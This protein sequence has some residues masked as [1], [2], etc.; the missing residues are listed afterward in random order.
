MR[1]PL[2]PAV[3]L[4]LALVACIPD[5]TGGDSGILSD[6]GTADGGTTDG[7]TTD[8]GATDG[9]TT[10]G[11]ATDGGATDGG[12]SEPAWIQGQVSGEVRVQLYTLR[13]S[14]GER[15]AV[16]WEDTEFGETFPFGAI[17]VA[18]TQDDGA[19]RLAYRGQDTIAAP[20]VAG[21]PYSV[22]VSLPEDGGVQLYATLD[23]HGDGILS[24]TEPIGTFPGQVMVTDGSAEGDKDIVILVNYDE[25]LA[26]WQG[27]GGP[28]GGTGTCD[29]PVTLSGTASI[30]TS[31]A[32]GDVAV[33]LYDATGAGPYTWDRDEPVSTGGGAEAPFSLGVCGPLGEM[34][35]LGAW[36]SN[37]NGLIDLADMWGAVISKPEVSAN[38]LDIQSTDLAGLEVQIPL[39]DGRSDLGVVPFVSLSGRV[40]YMNGQVFDKLPTDSTVH[41]VAM[42]YRPDG[43]LQVTELALLSYDTDTWEP[44]DYAGQTELPFHLWV[45]GN[46]LVYLWGFVDEGPKPDGTVNAP[47]ELVGSGGGDLTGRLPTGTSSTSDLR[48]DLG[49]G[50]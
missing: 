4:A 25:A 22:N 13:E 23:Y 7:G 17:M 30:T 19:G 49:Y 46:T 29:D 24:T 20:T 39:G 33:L 12:T 2:I 8:G 1:R 16:A 6:G 47:F 32:G 38:P 42:L 37:G 48:V 28:G 27:G 11:G 9:G 5:P 36:D 50:G 40:T 44:A 18:A 35:L 15:E 10:D 3:L 34:N 45:P 31:W 43:E 14:D 26:W 21:D 41:V